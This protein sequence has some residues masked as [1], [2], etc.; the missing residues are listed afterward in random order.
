MTK[1]TPKPN[2]FV[3]SRS[4]VGS[5]SGIPEIKKRTKRSVRHA[6]KQALPGLAQDEDDRVEAKLSDRTYRGQHPGTAKLAE[7][8][9]VTVK[10]KK[11]APAGVKARKHQNLVASKKRAVA[12]EQKELE[13]QER[14]KANRRAK[15]RAAARALKKARQ[16]VEQE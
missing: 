12:A 5:R 16:K 1:R 2:R 6:S 10:K 11:R 7:V 8:A 3:Q 9:V 4:K 13:R 14:L 15:R